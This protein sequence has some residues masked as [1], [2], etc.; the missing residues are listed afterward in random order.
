MWVAESAL[1]SSDSLSYNLQVTTSKLST[2]IANAEARRL[3][4][5]PRCLFCYP[6]GDKHIQHVKVSFFHIRDETRRV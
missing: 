2:G 1:A 6:L 3:Y 5:L 4:T